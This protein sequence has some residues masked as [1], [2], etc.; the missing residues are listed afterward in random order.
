M[1]SCSPSHFMWHL[2]ALF[3]LFA[4]C[5]FFVAAVTCRIVLFLRSIFSHSLSFSVYLP[6]LFRVCVIALFCVILFTHC[7]TKVYRVYPSSLI[8][9]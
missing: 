3:N 4:E 2:W 6:H 1:P 7:M 5:T 9:P 8:K